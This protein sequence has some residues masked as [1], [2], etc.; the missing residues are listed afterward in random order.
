MPLA[1]HDQKVVVK[2]NNI[3]NQNDVEDVIKTYWKLLPNVKLLM[4]VR[5]PI[6]RYVSDIVHYNS[7]RAKILKNP[8]ENIN[9]V[10]QG[11]AKTGKYYDHNGKSIVRDFYY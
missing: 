4:I 6:Y 10:V 7:I 3:W 9:D 2:G 8:I 11:V 5:D 1:Y